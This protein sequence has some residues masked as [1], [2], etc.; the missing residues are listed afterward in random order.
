PI[1]GCYDLARTLISNLWL[2]E[3]SDENICHCDLPD[4]DVCRHFDMVIGAVAGLPSTTSP[5]DSDRGAGPQCTCATRVWREAGSF[6]G[7]AEPTA[8]RRISECIRNRRGASSSRCYSAP[9]QWAEPV[10][11]HWNGSAGRTAYSSMGR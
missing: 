6:R 7:L 1:R 10:S 9:Q 2:P 3:V 4:G 5:E 8:A 11:G